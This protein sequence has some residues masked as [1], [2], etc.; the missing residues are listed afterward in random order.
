M[1]VAIMQPYFLPYIGYFQLIKAVD[2]FVLY[3]DVNYINKG[4]I[5]RNNILVN[6]KAFMFTIPLKEASQNKLINQIELSDDPKWRTK[7]LQTVGQSYKKASHFNVVYPILERVLNG[8]SVR[9]SD[10]IFESIQ[11]INQYL[12][13]TTTIVRS[14]E[15]YQ[16][17][18]LKAQERIID[19]CGQ[20]N[21]KLYINPIGGQELYDQATFEKQSMTLRFI[22]TK[23]IVYKQFQN[24]FV[25][26]LSIL[27][28]LMF[29]DVAEINNFLD[30]YE[31][32]A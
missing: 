9:V 25:P 5:N 14:S 4:W 7:L 20:E 2:T 16:N 19:I 23:P 13:I 1:K 21:A 15:I 11:E 12:G 6:G 26:F 30:L 28:V 29:C 32:V 18:N 3:D 31:L 27:D 22:R 8:A 17:Q 10:L 24:D